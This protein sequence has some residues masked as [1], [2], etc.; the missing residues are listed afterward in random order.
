MIMRRATARSD[1]G[2]PVN[3]G[4]IASDHFASSVSWDGTTL[5]FASARPGGAGGNDL[6]LMPIL[7]EGAP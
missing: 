4:H 6:W 3:L 5:Y 7:L 1:W 2:R